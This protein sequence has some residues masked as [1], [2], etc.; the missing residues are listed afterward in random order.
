MKMK[1]LLHSQPGDDIIV[2]SLEDLHGA[3]EEHWLDYLQMTKEAFDSQN[4][5]MIVDNHEQHNSDPEYIEH[6]LGPITTN[7]SF[8]KDKKALDFGCGCGRNIKNLLDAAD[9][10]RVDGCDISK[11]NADYS[12]EYINQFYS[13][14]RC[15]TWETDGYTLRPAP[16]EEYDFVMSHIVFQHIANHAIRF[17]ILVEMHRILKPGGMIN[18]HFM[19]LALDSVTYH[20]CYPPFNTTPEELGVDK[21]SLL[22]CIVEDKDY[23]IKDLEQV[24]F[25]EVTCFVG[26]DKYS[27]HPSYYARGIK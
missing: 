10:Q 8:W 27:H 13:D 19:D 20:S 2:N 26:K 5:L 25:Q 22:N 7:R 17:S 15:A 18:V 11:Q 23:I 12:K 1:K 6:I 24:G 4:N 9:F 3:I 21:F 14:D 16:D